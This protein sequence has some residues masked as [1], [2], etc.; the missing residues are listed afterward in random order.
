MQSIR[1]LQPFLSGLEEGVLFLGEDRRIVAINTAATQ[2][3]GKGESE[4][5]GRLC[6]QVFEGAECARNCMARNSCTLMSSKQQ[7]TLTDNLSL[8]HPSGSMVFL[9]MWAVLLPEPEISASCAVILR[10]RTREILLEEQLNER[11]RLGEMIG[12]GPAMQELFRN[13]LRNAGSSATAL[14]LGES[15]TGKEL[16]ARALHDN[17]NRAQ[18]PYIRVHCASFSENLLESELFGH[19]KGAFTGA[20]INRVGRFEAAHGGSILLDEIGE[21]S[22]T[23]QVKLLRVLQEREVEP[24]GGNKPRKVDVRIIAATNRDLKAMIRDG[25]F[26]EDLYYRL[27]V[28]PIITPPL[29]ERVEDIPLLAQV[30]LGKMTERDG[31]KDVQLSNQ[32]ISTLE[33]YPWPGNVRELSNA[34]E[35]ALVQSIGEIILPSHFPKELTSSGMIPEYAPAASAIPATSKTIGYY[36]KSDDTSEREQIL[37]ALQETGGNKVQ[38]SK[39]LGMSRTTLWKKIKSYEITL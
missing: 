24:V 13:I 33:S 10:D 30:L 36:R 4:V 16:V 19:I 9:K 2:M 38:A 12:H 15:G 1:A 26:R 28:L 3:I 17:S 27:N 18:G 35:Y 32:A 39:L 6:P 14:V 21:I 29:R 11:L 25:K 23:I 8:N 34:L 22:A 5:V 37:H 31:R 7:T 20:A